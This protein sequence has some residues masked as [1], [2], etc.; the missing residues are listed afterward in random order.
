VKAR[1]LYQLK[2]TRGGRG[3]AFLAGPER[4]DRVEV[5]DLQSGEVLYLWDLSPRHASR[6]LR[7]LR[8]DLSTMEAEEFVEAWRHAEG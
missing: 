8:E 1:L 5:V 2:V 4:L 6:V 7:A 3:P